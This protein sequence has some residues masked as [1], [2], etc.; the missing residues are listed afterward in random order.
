MGLPAPQSNPVHVAPA[1]VA[2]PAADSLSPA[3]MASAIQ[4]CTVAYCRSQTALFMVIGKASLEDA[5]TG[6]SA[7]IEELAGAD[8]AH[9]CL[10]AVRLFGLPFGLSL[11][12]FELMIHALSDAQGLYGDKP[13]PVLEAEGELLLGSSGGYNIHVS[14]EHPQLP[15]F[16]DVAKACCFAA[17]TCGQPEWVE[18]ER[19]GQVLP[20]CRQAT[21]FRQAMYEYLSSTYKI[22]IEAHM[23]RLFQDSDTDNDEDAANTK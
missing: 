18:I 3:D 6:T 5:V 13:H 23:E 14:A 11:D 1:P 19:Y 16:T 12:L 9:A 15:I 2:A 21:D 22:N 8:R 10:Q 4:A 17:V 20:I 7:S